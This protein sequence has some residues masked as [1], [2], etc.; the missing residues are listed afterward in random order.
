MSQP[1]DPDPDRVPDLVRGSVVVAVDGSDHAARAARWATEQAHL[2]HRRL[3]VVAVGDDAEGATD[4]AVAAARREHPDLSVVGAAVPG[5]PR[6]VLIDASAHAHL[7][8]VG[9]R[10]R[11]AV[12]SLLLGSVSATVSAQATCPVVVCH[13]PTDDEARAGVVVG[14]DATPESLP[15]IEFAYR[16]ASLRHLPL[17]VLHSFWDA[18][19]GVA[20][21][22]EAQGEP[23]DRPA[24]EDLRATLSQSVAGLSEQYPDVTVTFTLKHGFADE[25]LTPG[26][27]GW[28]LIVV[29]R[30]PMSS[31]ERL[32]TGSVA[33]SVI[34]RAHTTVAVVPPP[35][36]A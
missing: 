31:L 24:L 9:S 32:L 23:V 28:D 12:R 29:G 4:D 16:Q 22:Y 36:S 13:P 26:H 15:V 25:A 8:V 7:L 11:G 33:T 6:T 14:A 3:V 18:A 5:D 19:A 30:H 1:L 17:T 21:Y 10:G 27:G 20:Q 34:E 35:R 2:E